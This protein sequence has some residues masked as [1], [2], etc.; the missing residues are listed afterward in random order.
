MSANKL[1]NSGN[2]EYSE[3]DFF[4]A[5]VVSEERVDGFLGTL[6][7][8]RDGLNIDYYNH[9]DWQETHTDWSQWHT[10]GVLW[11]PGSVTWYLDGN[12]LMS[13]LYGSN[14]SPS[15]LPVNVNGITPAPPGIFSN[16]GDD[17]MGQQ[18]VIGSDPNWPLMIDWVRVWSWEAAP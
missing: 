3:L 7:D 9:N 5:L 12:P 18:I 4:E 16:L 8:W 17:S 15:P 14:I 11:I 6:P 13:Q 1:Q 2:S 10:V